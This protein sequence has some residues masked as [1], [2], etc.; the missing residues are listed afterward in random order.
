MW[1]DGPDMMAE[2]L[3]DTCQILELYAMSRDDDAVCV[4][5]ERP[6]FCG[7]E[8]LRNHATRPSETSQLHDLVARGADAVK[9]MRIRQRT[10]ARQGTI[11]RSHLRMLLN[12]VDVNNGAMTFELQ[13]SVPPRICARI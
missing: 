2:G 12:K 6:V 9:K 8:L 7:I 13:A 3:T 1:R 10:R 5:S 4:M 11:L